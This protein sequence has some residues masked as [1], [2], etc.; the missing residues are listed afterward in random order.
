MST[1]SQSLTVRILA[2]SSQFRQELESITSQLESFKSTTASLGNASQGISRIGT[3]ISNLSR[4]LQST[5]QLTRQL[6]QQLQA[7]SRISVNVNVSPA[8]NSL[9]RLSST[10]L[11]VMAQLRALNTISVGPAPSPS[12]GPSFPTTGFT[13]RIGFANGGLVSGT[14]GRDRI[15][16]ML[17]AG[18]FV[19]RQPSVNQLG[20]T[21][22]RAL[23]R[24]PRTSI[25]ATRRPAQHSTTHQTHNQIG[26]INVHIQHP[27]SLPNLMQNVQDLQRTLRLHRG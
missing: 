14:P 4:P 27:Q 11:Q 18:E 19:L 12:T 24:N 15:P 5:I 9:T 2:D 7:I 13:P 6:R 20:L 21:F 1:F 26:D 3:Q 10:I 23:N 17:T 8:I 22:L 16:A 25:S